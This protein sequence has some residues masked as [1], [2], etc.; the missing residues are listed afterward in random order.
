MIASEMLEQS[1]IQVPASADVLH[2]LVARTEK[3]LRDAKLNDRSLAEPRAKNCLDVQVSRESTDRA[4][5]ILDALLKALEA[6]GFSVTVKD[7]PKRTTTLSIL[8]ETLEFGLEEIVARQEHVLS[9]A[10]RK[11]KEK[12]PWSTYGIPQYDFLPTGRFSLKL[13]NLWLRGVRMTWSDGKVQRL[14]DRL[15]AFIVGLINAAVRKR[16]DRLERERREREW[17]EERRRREEKARLIRQEKERLAGLEKEAENWRKSQSL[18]AYIDAVRESA[19]REHGEIREG[20]ELD[21][22][23]IWAT[24]QADRLDPLTDSPPSILDEEDRYRYW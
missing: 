20:G 12:S 6:R 15:N 11:K 9:S 2:P 23:L 7:E 18:R 3:S 10:E 13:K 19:I 22:W 21:R 14:E 5:R 16:E 17:E 24:E 8:D 4:V 1:R